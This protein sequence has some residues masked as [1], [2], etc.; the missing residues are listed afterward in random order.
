MVGYSGDQEVQ[1]EYGR[2]RDSEEDD[3]ER[4]QN[5]EDSQAW[6]YC[7]TQRGFQEVRINKLQVVA[8]IGKGN[9]T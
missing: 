6:E 5:A 4:G 1:G 9:Y 8:Y 3:D 2:G 7:H